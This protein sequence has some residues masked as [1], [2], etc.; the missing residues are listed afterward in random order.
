MGKIIKK[1]SFVKTKVGVGKVK[2]VD[3]K[4]YAIPLFIIKL[5]KGKNK[6]EEVAMVESQLKRI[7]GRKR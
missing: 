3:R 5:T 1:G 6:G 2:R 4:T 7:K